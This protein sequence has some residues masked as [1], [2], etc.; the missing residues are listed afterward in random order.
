M[1]SNAIF[2][3]AGLITPLV[4]LIVMPRLWRHILAGYVL[5]LYILFAFAGFAPLLILLLIG[6][7]P[8]LI[9]QAKGHSFLIW[10]GYGAVLPIVA[11]PHALLLK[12]PVEPPTVRE[13]YS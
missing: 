4:L 13:T 6:L 3:I 10:W 2:F 5:F 7:I 1:N 9:A 12:R 8:A 11:L